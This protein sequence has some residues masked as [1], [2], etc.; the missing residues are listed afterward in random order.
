MNLGRPDWPDGS[1]IY[2]GDEANLRVVG[3]LEFEHD[4][5][6]IERFPV[7]VVEPV[8]C[9]RVPRLLVTA[10]TSWDASRMYH[11]PR[12]DKLRAALGDIMNLTTLEEVHE[13]ASSALEVDNDKQE[14]EA[15]MRGQGHGE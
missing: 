2:R 13:R 14:I 3:R 12:R 8:T 11:D 10:A 5:D 15:E 4:S 6:G 1:V 7:L 9:P